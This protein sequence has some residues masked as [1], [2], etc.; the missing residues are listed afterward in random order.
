MNEETSNRVNYRSLL[1]FRELRVNWKRHYFTRSRFGFG[2]AAFF[3][4]EIRKR[5]LEVQ[6]IRIIDFRWNSLAPQMFPQLIALSAMY[7]ELVIHMPHSIRFVRQRQAHADPGTR[8]QLAIAGCVP[9]PQF[10]PVVQVA[11]TASNRL[12]TPRI[13]Y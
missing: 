13:S 8:K 9:A 3:V 2:Q 11:C 12:F 10:R 1:I 7:G 4:A 5:R 6:W